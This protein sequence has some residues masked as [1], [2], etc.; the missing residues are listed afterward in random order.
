MTRL[1]LIA[2][3]WCVGVNAHAQGIDG[4]AAVMVDAVPNENAAEMRPRLFAEHRFGVGER[5]RF[6][7]AGFAEGLVADRSAGSVSTTAL[8]RPQELHVEFLWPRADLRVGLSRVVWGRL[9]EFLPTD[10]V[11]PL[12]LTRFFLEGR[13]E[14][15][16]PV[17][18]VRARVLPSDSLMLEGVW[19]PFFRRGSFDQL[20]E[21]SSPFNLAPRVPV[22]ENEPARTAANGQ[23][24]IRASFTAGRVDWAVSA[25]RGF[26][27]LPYYDVVGFTVTE[28]FSRFAMV[29][30][31]FETV[32]GEWGVRGEVAARGDLVEGG[33][34]VDRRAGAYRVSGNL[35][36]SDAESRREAT[37]VASVDRSFV[38]ETRQVRAFAVYNPSEESGFV[39]VI[40][41]LSMRDNVTFETSGGVF[42]GS[43]ANTLGRLATRDF[44]YVRLKVFF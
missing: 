31:D 28:R 8:I 38:R 33:V 29:G 40:L 41:S 19:V 15:R 16:I 26:E 17:G 18:M 14:A 24:G 23:G 30:A 27:S 3:L 13:V 42:A 22:V 12:D 7:V 4:Y 35:M 21:S 34:G 25:Y 20:D 9:D 37:L 2:A 43:G 1:A 11:N 32:R 6:T 39:R 5:V 44:V 10:V 36:F